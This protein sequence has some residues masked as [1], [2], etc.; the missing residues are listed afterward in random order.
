MRSGTSLDASMAFLRSPSQ[1]PVV[2]LAWAPSGLLLASACAGS[3]GFVVWD[4]AQGISTP[5]AAGV[6]STLPARHNAS[7]FSCFVVISSPVCYSL[8]DLSSKASLLLVLC[9]LRL[10]TACCG[11]DL[12]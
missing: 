9:I 1:A 10:D 2:A 5:L 12:S 6:P 3:P 7:K 4:V 8:I 11:M